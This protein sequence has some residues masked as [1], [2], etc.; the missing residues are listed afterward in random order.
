MPATRKER[1][2]AGGRTRPR[3]PRAVRSCG[4]GISAGRA[5][6]CPAHRPPAR[7]ALA[8]ILA[9]RRP[10]RGKGT[11][12]VLCAPAAGHQTIEL[13]STVHRRRT[14]RWKGNGGVLLLTPNA[15]RGSGA[16]PISLSS[17]W[18]TGSASPKHDAWRLASVKDQRYPIFCPVAA[19]GPKNRFLR[20]PA[21][22]L[23]ALARSSCDLLIAAS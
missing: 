5:R 22:R 19:L 17:R 16:K 15:P 12:R 21:S 7:D 10:W 18:L 8:R 4:C 1:P 23:R 3:A 2:G 9:D 11:L 13:H 20:C 6:S 14:Y